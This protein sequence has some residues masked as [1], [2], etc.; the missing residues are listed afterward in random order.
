MYKVYK[1]VSKLDAND[2]YIGSTKK[3]LSVRLCGHIDSARRASNKN[4]KQRW[5][6]DNIGYLEII[7]IDSTEDKK[8]ALRKER[9]QIILH[10][11]QEYHVLNTALPNVFIPPQDVHVTYSEQYRKCGKAEC[12]KCKNGYLH[13]PYVYAYWT[14][15]D[16]LKSAYVGKKMVV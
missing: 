11:A 13:G 7:E 2:V 8:D 14:G 9:A 5:V 15:D 1:I 6:L 10:R 3:R 4:E 16:K 12:V